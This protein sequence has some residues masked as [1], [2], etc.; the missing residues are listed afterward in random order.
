MQKRL[1]A[2]ASEPSNTEK[3]LSAAQGV[4]NTLPV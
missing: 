3:L 4:I 2:A 1:A